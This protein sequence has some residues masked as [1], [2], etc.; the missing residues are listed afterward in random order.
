MRRFLRQTDGISA[1]EFSIVAP[2]FIIFMLWFFDVS[3]SL[4]VKNS[5]HH[6]VGTVARGVY[7]D[8]ATAEAEIKEDMDEWIEK[9]GEEVITT[10]TTE[11][12]GE[13][14]YRVIDAK[15]T[16]TYKTP[17]FSGKSITLE[18]KGRAPILTY[19]L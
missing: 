15:M 1:V 12:V 7:L 8:P 17:P 14:D 10:I 16:Y 3:Y 19:Q 2:I 13:I 4:Y 5:F 9:F 18:A 6:A 11:T